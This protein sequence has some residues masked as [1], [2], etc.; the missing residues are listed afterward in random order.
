[1]S[2]TYEAQGVELDLDDLVARLQATAAL[3]HPAMDPNY[4]LAILAVLGTMV[5]PV[6]GG[7]M[8]GSEFRHRTAKERAA[9]AGWARLVAQSG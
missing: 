9:H 4:L 5:L 3:L 6:W 7:H 2:A 1:M 8:A